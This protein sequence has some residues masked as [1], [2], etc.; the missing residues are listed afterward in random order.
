MGDYSW[1]FMQNIIRKSTLISATGEKSRTRFF[2]LIRER[3]HAFQSNSVKSL[4]Q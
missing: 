1:T 3:I 4:F 2:N